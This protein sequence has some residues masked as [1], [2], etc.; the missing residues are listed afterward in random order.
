MRVHEFNIPPTIIQLI[1]D[2][3]WPSDPGKVNFQEFEPIVKR[4]IVRKLFPGNDKIVLMAPPFHTISDEVKQ[5]NDFWVRHLTNPGEIDYDKAIIFADF[6]LGSDSPII[7]YYKKM[8]RPAV[9]YLNWGFDG[10]ELHHSWV[11]SHESIDDFCVD[12]GLLKEP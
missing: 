8:D 2:G 9:L 4:E 10:G 12:V 5:G 7:L 1:D 3:I 6:G 11:K